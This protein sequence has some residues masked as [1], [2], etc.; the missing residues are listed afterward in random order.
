MI[1]SVA[2]SSVSHS[3]DMLLNRRPDKLQFAITLLAIYRSQTKSITFPSHLEPGSTVH[4]QIL[5]ITLQNSA[6][7]PKL[8]I[9]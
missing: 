4:L 9:P 7:I 5:E 3:Q 8:L 2:V 1:N 6:V